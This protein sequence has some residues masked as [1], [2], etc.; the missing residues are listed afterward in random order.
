MCSR[1]LINKCSVTWRKEKG[2]MRREKKEGGRNDRRTLGQLSVLNVCGNR[3]HSQAWFIWIYKRFWRN[4]GKHK[5]EENIR[6]CVSWHRSFQ[7]I[8]TSCWLFLLVDLRLWYPKI[9][10][11]NSVPLANW[12][13]PWL[14]FDLKVIQALLGNP[15]LR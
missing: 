6:A 7:W 1:H 11:G 2:C 5:T 10:E 13:S 15:S 12:I 4:W 14:D 8:L 3:G 9:F